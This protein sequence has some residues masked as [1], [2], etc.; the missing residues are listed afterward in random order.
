M[1]SG[2]Q[3]VSA[4]SSIDLAE[5]NERERA[6]LT[7]LDTLLNRQIIGQEAAVAAIVPPI[8]KSKMGM[9]AP[10]RPNASLFFL[11]PTGVGKTQLA[12]ELAAHVFGS[13][14]LLSVD[15]SGSVSLSGTTAGSNV[16]V[17]GTVI[18][19]LGN[20][21]AAGNDFV[22]NLDP[23]A[24]AVNL[25]TLAQVSDRVRQLLA[26]GNKIAAIK[27]YKEENGV[28]LVTATKMIESL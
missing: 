24:N 21:I 28:D 2:S 9:S 20:T 3:V 11:G 12:K 8:R 1:A 4:M 23:D 17:S 15:T 22:V 5:L 7:N 14:D 16:S 26:S 25:Q 6:T 18:G 27:A 10:N 13:E 19:T